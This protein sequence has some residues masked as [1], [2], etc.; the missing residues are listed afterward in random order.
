MMVLNQNGFDSDGLAGAGAVVD[1]AEGAVNENGLVSAGLTS[2]SEPEAEVLPNEKAG[3]G[4][5]AGTVS[6]AEAPFAEGAP[7]FSPNLKEEEAPELNENAGLSVLDDS[8]F[9]PL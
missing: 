9:I 4:A 3:F 8:E 7:G 6:G 1:D 5:E 2:D